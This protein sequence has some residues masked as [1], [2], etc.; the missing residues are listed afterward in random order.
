M[1]A[2]YRERIDIFERI[3]HDPTMWQS[4]ELSLLNLPVS[5]VITGHK[6]LKQCFPSRFSQ[7]IVRGSVRNHDAN[8]F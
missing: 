6:G 1:Y 7:N 8:E 5:A 2:V 3:V 4:A